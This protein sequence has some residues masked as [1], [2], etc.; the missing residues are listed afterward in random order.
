MEIGYTFNFE[1]LKKV[2]ISSLRL[3][4]NGSNLLTIDGVKDADPEQR[5]ASLDAYPLRK[6]VNFGVQATF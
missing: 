5:N 6:I 1:G 4:A 2:G 3:Y